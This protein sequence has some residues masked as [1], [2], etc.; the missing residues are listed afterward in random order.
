MSA[1]DTLRRFKA[2]KV[3]PVLRVVAYFSVVVAC[4][5]AWATHEAKAS[6]GEQAFVVGRDLSKL[7]EFLDHTYEVKINGQTVY[8]ARIDSPLSQK[9]ILDRYEAVCR[10]NPGIVGEAW[11]SLP[12]DAQKVAGKGEFKGM[13]ASAG[14]IRK[15]GEHEGMVVCLAKGEN[16]AASPVEA[17]EKFTRTGEL[18]YVGKLRYVYVAGPSSRGRWTVTTL[19]TENAF[20]VNHIMLP[21]GT[22]DAPGTDSPTAG[23]PPNAQRIFSANITGAPYGFRLYESSAS[24]E[25]IYNKFDATMTSDDW[26]VFSPGP[27]SAHVYLK[28]GVETMVHVVP[29]AKGGHALVMIN[30]LGGDQLRSGP[31]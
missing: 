30:E 20:N 22:D 18:S 26:Q 15:D 5:G 16:M 11:K 31:R 23:R 12:A 29:Q 28:D 1:F 4:I 14:V 7:A 24:A 3:M 25:A 17:L 10:D 9:E 27:D 6:L 13:V 19:W 21:E 2:G 8:M